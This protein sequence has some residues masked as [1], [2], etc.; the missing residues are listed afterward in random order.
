MGHW[1]SLG[2]HWAAW[3]L[4][5]GWKGPSRDIGWLEG[6]AVELALLSTRGM[7]VHNADVLIWSDNKGIIGA[8]TKGRCSNPMTNLSIH[9]SDKLHA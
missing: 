9:C 7:G 6:V 4:K 5:D 3:C 1:P 2:E 8:F